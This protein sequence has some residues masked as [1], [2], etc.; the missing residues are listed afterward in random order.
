MSDMTGFLVRKCM[1]GGVVVVKGAGEIREVRFRRPYI[2]ITQM[3][4]G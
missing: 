3:G 4:G 2:V 1:G